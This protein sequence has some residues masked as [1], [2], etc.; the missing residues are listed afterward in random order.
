MSITSYLSRNEQ[1]YGER[2]AI[3]FI[4]SDKE[5]CCMNWRELNEFSNKVAN[6]L[7]TKGISK[8]D[9][10]AILLS[11][12]L[13][14]MPIYFGILKMGAV[15]VPLNYNNHID[16]IIYYVKYA[17]CKGIFLS[18][19]NKCWDIFEKTDDIFVYSIDNLTES[20]SEYGADDIG[21]EL[22]DKDAAA[23]YF[24][25]GTTG[26]S[27][28]VLLSHGAL[29]SAAEIELSH[30]NQKHEDKFLCLTP[31]YHTG[32]KIHWF[33]SL[34]VGGTLV[35]ATFTSPL[36]IMDVME[37]EKISIVWLLV[38]QIQDILDYIESRDISANEKLS[39]LR[40][41]HSGA[42]PVPPS[43]ILRWHNKFPHILYDTNYGLT[44]STG[45]GC[46][47]LGVKNI[48]K[49]GAIGK[50]DSN[51]LIDIVND[52]GVSVENEIIGELILKGPGVMCEYYKDKEATDKTL[53]KGWLY[54]GDMAYKDKD[55]FI[56][57]VD[58]KKDIIISGGENIYPVQI[59]SY[60]RSLE[61][62]KDVAVIGLPS[63]R[64]GEIVAA[65]IELKEGFLCSKKDIFMYCKELPEYQRPM[66]IYFGTVA[67][68]ATG[69]IDKKLLRN[70][71]LN[72]QSV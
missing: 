54:T 42:Q 9:K 34:L 38:P 41:M 15:V 1:Q 13:L 18:E 61:C 58:R 60:I 68:N 39:A 47:H 29:Q 70:K 8:G 37:R 6:M 62:I 24:S 17:D 25:S 51:W 16:D 48:E 44:E 20:M 11:N 28:A 64:M 69:K 23:I 43:L 65:V 57:L 27:K 66:R 22:L 14:W 30:H 67:R 32:S 7:I 19:D 3:V 49:A 46:I 72:R 59:E 56:Y 33:G 10:I 53:K 2:E 40:L 71:M 36:C 52:S 63:K 26:K 21:I 4:N 5:R 35:I 31:L 45:P 55:G 50:P 12:S